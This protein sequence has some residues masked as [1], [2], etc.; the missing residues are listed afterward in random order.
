M[1]GIP[2]AD[3]SAYK[4]KKEAEFSLP[5]GYFGTKTSTAGPGAI[6]GAPTTKRNYEN[7]IYTFE[8][9]R[10]MLETHRQLMGRD[11]TANANKMDTAADGPVLMAAPQILVPPVPGMPP[12]SALGMPPPPL[13]MTGPPG[14]P[15][16]PLGMSPFGM[17]GMPPFPPGP[18][19]LGAP[20]FPP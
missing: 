15:P 3:V 18:G 7:R 5:L 12:M 13:S 19:G 11:E 10:G 4:R 9:L 20:P 17:P 2:A 16:M 8:E 14:V 6:P 1:E